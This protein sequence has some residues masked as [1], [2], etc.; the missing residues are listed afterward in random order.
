MAAVDPSHG[1]AIL[2]IVTMNALFL[3]GLACRVMTR[4]FAAAWDG[5]MAAVYV[6]AVTLA[7]WL[8][9]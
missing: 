3:I 4:R 5:A 7:C 6:V 9:G 1:V 8:R 2:A